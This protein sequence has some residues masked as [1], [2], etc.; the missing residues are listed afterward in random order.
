MPRRG[1]ALGHYQKLKHSDQ[2]DLKNRHGDLDHQ[3][4]LL[5]VAQ[6]LG[7][8]HQ[9]TDDQGDDR[10]IVHDVVMIKLPMTCTVIALVKLPETLFGNALAPINL[11][12][13]IILKTTHRQEMEM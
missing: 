11:P 1:L 8:F 9:T 2:S 4:D 3:L 5:G 10:R 6:G 7:E 12:P 13:Q